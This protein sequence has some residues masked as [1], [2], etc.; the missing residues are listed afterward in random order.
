MLAA[1][2][3][4][5]VD[6]LIMRGCEAVRSVPQV[7]FAMAFLA[8]FGGG[9]WNLAIVLGVSN[10]PGYTRMM[11]AQTLRI[12]N[13]DYIVA[14]RLQGNKTLRLMYKHIFP[15]CISPVIVMMTQQ[16]GSTILA[17]AGLSFLG[18]GISIPMASWG[19]MVSDGKAY[20]LSAPM[21]A[22]APGL[23]VAALVIALNILGDGVRD[24]LDPRLRGE[25]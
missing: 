21:F 22:L 23:C 1:Y 5:I 3:G 10:V 12:K 14:G 4:G 15:N 19:C 18:V 11:R 13:A 7:V 8:V 2:F 20:L 17:E 25:V 16:V 9:F 6:V 24:A